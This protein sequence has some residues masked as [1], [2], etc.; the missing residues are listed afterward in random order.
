MNPP[1]QPRREVKNMIYLLSDL[2]GKLDFAGWQEYKNRT[3]SDEVLILLGDVRLAEPEVPDNAQFTE[4]ILSIKKPVWIVDGNHENFEYLNSMPEE[5]WNGGKVH[6]LTDN[7]LH[8]QRGYVYTIAGKKFFI[9]G[10]TSPLITEE[11]LNRGYENLKK[12]D[13]CVDFVLTH[14]YYT[15]RDPE[16]IKPFEKLLDFIDEKV[17][18]QQWYCGHHHVNKAWDEKHTVVYDILKPI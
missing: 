8:L 1:L 12:H 3:D 5:D 11:E 18:F 7:I 6:R 2:H 9:F 17:E 14:D 10:G 15:R 13:L 4:E 16:N